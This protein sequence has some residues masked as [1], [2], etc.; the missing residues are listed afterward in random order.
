MNNR[1]ASID[2]S[3]DLV[4][5]CQSSR[6]RWADSIANQIAFRTGKRVE[7]YRGGVEEWKNNHD[8]K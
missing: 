6:C 2:K 1:I 8:A 7:I 4:V 3:K 5:Y